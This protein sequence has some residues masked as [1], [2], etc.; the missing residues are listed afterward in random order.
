VQYQEIWPASLWYHHDQ[1]N[2]LDRP[3]GLSHLHQNL[4]FDVSN[5]AHP[6]LTD[7]KGCTKCCLAINHQLFQKVTAQIPSNFTLNF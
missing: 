4:Q 5:K 3:T 6:I 7:F 1:S 2:D